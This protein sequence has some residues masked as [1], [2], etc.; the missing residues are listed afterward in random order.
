MTPHINPSLQATREQVELLLAANQLDALRALLQAQHPAD[1]ADLMEGIGD[2][3][4]RVAVFRLLESGVAAEV[5]DETSA[6]LTRDIVE[7]VPT[8]EIADLLEALPEDDAV[9]ILSELKEDQAEAILALME[10]EEAA[11]VNVLLAFP[12]DT[13]GR[14]MS[15]H[16]VRLNEEWTVERTQEYL[17]TVDPDVETLT[18]LYV[19]NGGGRLVGVVP[20]RSLITAK[21]QM[22]IGEIMQRN[23]ISVRAASDQEDVARMVTQYDFYAI[24]VV[25]DAGRLVGVI[26]HDDVVDVLQ[27]EFT[28][29]AQRFGGSEPL[30]DEYLSTPVFTVWRK[31]VGWLAILFLTEM[32]TGSVMRLFEHELDAAVALAFFVPLMIG[33]GGNSGSQTTATII[34]ALSTG[35]VQFRD[36]WRLL[37]HELRTGIL[38]GI[39]MAV[40]GFARAL[41]WGTGQS[42]ALTVGLALLTIVIWANIIGALLPV[43]AARLKIDP[44]VI[45]GPVMSTLVDATGLF[46]YF[47]LARAIL[48]L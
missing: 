1:I 39:A 23:V 17:R 33:T 3:D 19:V 6:E 47:S 36:S 32:L 31:R 28:E 5:L 8:A 11:D 34:R 26:T 2:E 29:D 7:A 12:E 15:V 43:L 27:D 25:D 38:L 44:A 22:K 35:E 4:Q 18:Y 24:P 41:L 46:I 20:L 48:G 40:L 30:E 9:E 42:L 10:P 21:L 14:L 45:S 37:W 16:V 13:A